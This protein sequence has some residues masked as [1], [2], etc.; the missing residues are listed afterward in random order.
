MSTVY[1]LPA[2]RIEISFTFDEVI[3]K[4]RNPYSEVCCQDDV[5]NLTYLSDCLKE[6]IPR[7]GEMFCVNKVCS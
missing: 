7:S 4:G 3:L 5:F 6:S 2:L 1:T